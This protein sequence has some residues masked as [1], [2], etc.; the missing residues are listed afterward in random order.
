[1]VKQVAMKLFRRKVRPRVD[2]VIAEYTRRVADS[3]LFDAAWYL[4]TYPDLAGFGPGPLAHFCEH[5]LRE[6]RDPGPNFDTRRYLDAIPGAETGPLPPFL[7][8]LGV[9]ET[10]AGYPA[11]LRSDEASLVY[12]IRSSGLFDEAWYLDT[13]PDV[14]RDGWDAFAHYRAYGGAEL[15]D[16]GPGFDAEHY[17]LA[18]P[19]DRDTFPSPLDHYLRLGLRRGYRPTGVSRY[20]R[21]LAAHDDLTAPDR[22]RIAAKP[23]PATVV[24]LVIVGPD[25]GVVDFLG[26]LADQVGASWRATLL[27]GPGVDAA[28]WRSITAGVPADPR[29]ACVETGAEALAGLQD[30]DAVLLAA[31]A[32][33]LRPHACHAF[34]AALDRGAALGAY[35][36]HDRIDGARTRHAPVFTPAMSPALMR[37]LPYA[38]AVV[39]LRIARE[40]REALSSALGRLGDPDRAWADVL[41]AL[42][43]ARVIRIPLILHHLAVD[44]AVAPSRTNQPV[45]D[46]S[47]PPAPAPAAPAEP[48]P[49]V[50]IVIPTR[51]RSVLLRACIDSILALTDYPPER[52]RIVIVDNGS[53][54]AETARY[55]AE[56]VADPRVSVAPSPG[57][58][59]FAE[60]CNAGAEGADADVLV[61]LNNDTT[62]RR[63]DWLRRLAGAAARPGTGAVGARL[64][65][66]NG[67][68]QH[69]GVVLGI[70]G[71]GAHALV[72]LPE[73]TA[74][75]LDATR[76]TSAVTGACLAI[77]R[78]VFAEIGGFDPLLRIDYNDVDLCCAAQAAGYRNLYVAEALL[79]HHESVSRG[80]NA[81]LADQGRNVREAVRV[82]RRHAAVIRDD[83]SYNPNL[84]RER[85]GALAVPPRVVP[86]WRRH[87]S[88]LRRVLLLNADPAL[89]R[90]VAQQA[91]CLTAR[92][93]AVI[94][95]GPD[96]ADARA[97]PH[98]GQVR[99]SDPAAAATF[100]IREGVDAVV[101]H[102]A[103]FFAVTHHLGRRPLVY[104]VDHGDPPPGTYPDR[105]ARAAAILDKRYHA[106]LA[107]RVVST[108]P[109][110]RDG[111]FGQD[112]M[113]IRH[114]LAP[115]AA[116][117]DAWAKR[118]PALRERFGFAGRFVVV[119]LLSADAAEGRDDDVEDLVSLATDYAFTEPALAVRPLFVAAARGPITCSADRMP[120]DLAT[121][122][123]LGEADLSALL[124]A[125]DLYLAAGRRQSA[126]CGIASALAM[127][128]P[129]VASAIAAHRAYPIETAPDVPGLCRLIGPHAE[130]W[131]TGVVARAAVILPGADPLAVLADTIALDLDRDSAE[132]WM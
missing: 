75:T 80:A 116:W 132:H 45:P 64:L 127:G 96:R 20:G 110:A 76:E 24:C 38:G 114:D 69:G 63:P 12:L 81:T 1:M 100:A 74:R 27:R 53:S 10:E 94:L 129:V 56:A 112:A 93:F 95:G 47:R 13:Y 106:A 118:R 77:R 17:A 9:G 109:A 5:G 126:D 37:Q 29:I 42:D 83:P 40:T 124:A 66:P 26:S 90:W 18:Y 36:D 11:W 6:H 101:A 35:G 125:G 25:D 122:E 119:D 59:N 4:A 99:L 121:V 58:F 2:P 89:R 57:P 71:V 7:H 88:G 55:F 51:D 108:S 16:P 8:A 14:A 72:G 23:V 105:D 3:G 123:S 84:S 73:A 113:L 91:A 131:R 52:Y 62:V 117:S 21:W 130:R 79:H 32:S 103:P 22:E 86:P 111:L 49:T 54:E 82:R 104:C 61:F 65:Y 50:R 85:I 98:L 60:I 68:V 70:A 102:S 30:G 67:T 97:G 128:L 43:P 31:S 120:V 41:L 34:A 19:H 44:E 87:P 78:S 107:H 115:E 33:R 48:A 39:A 15:R 92:G 46:P 28:S